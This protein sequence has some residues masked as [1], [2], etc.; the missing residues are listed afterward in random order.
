MEQAEILGGVKDFVTIKYQGDDKV[1]LPV[2][3]LETIDRYMA[4]GGA[5]PVLD[6]QIGRASCRE[7]V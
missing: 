7:R 6:R 2:E 4:G 3:N 1:L 5:L